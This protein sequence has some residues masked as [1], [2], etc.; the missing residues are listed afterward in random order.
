VWFG[1]NSF[2][3]NSSDSFEPR[4]VS[5]PDEE[6]RFFD[7]HAFAARGYVD[8]PLD[9]AFL[10]EEEEP[11]FSFGEPFVLSVGAGAHSSCGNEK[12]ECLAITTF[13]TIR[14]ENARLV[15]QNG[16]PVP[17]APFDSTSGYD[18][19]VAPVPEPEA[20]ALMLASIVTITLLRGRLWPQAALRL[21][22]AACRFA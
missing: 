4:F 12:P 18:Y 6:P 15:D 8:I 13:R 7:G 1:D 19:D 10:D 11:L 21:G 2:V 3:T 22:D 14:I 17:G 9:E 5:Y 16:D 20:G